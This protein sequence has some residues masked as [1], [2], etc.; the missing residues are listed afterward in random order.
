MIRNGYMTDHTPPRDADANVDSSAPEGAGDP[1]QATRRRLLTVVGAGSAAFLAGCIGGDD[2]IDDTAGPNHPDDADANGGSDDDDGNEESTLDDLREAIAE[3]EDV[4]VAIDAGYRNTVEYV[5]SPD[6]GTGIHFINEEIRDLC[7][8]DP[9]VLVYDLTDD[10]M[11]ELLAA[12]WVVPAS[13]FDEAP[14]LFG[15]LFDGPHDPT[16]DGDQYD[17]HAW[18]L[19]ENPEGTFAPFNPDVSPPDYIEDLNAAY[20][21]L[22]A[23]SAV[24]DAVDA[25]Y[26]PQGECV[27]SSDGGMG[28]RYIHPEV[29]GLDP[30]EPQGLL[31]GCTDDDAR[32][33]AAEWLIPAGDVDEP[34]VLFGQEFDGPHDPNGEGDQYDLH[35]WLAETNP[36]GLFAPFNPRVEC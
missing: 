23:Y 36:A 8:I 3:Y 7:P 31:F 28:V 12:K 26:E 6:G 20:A 25:G 16:G 19:E 27:E 2:E 5:E 9:N 29:D 14:E 17:L 33:F 22:Q 21:S 15:Q 10:G 4:S 1:H 35:V 34:P 18:V 24:S 32:L 30:A 13:A 11:Y